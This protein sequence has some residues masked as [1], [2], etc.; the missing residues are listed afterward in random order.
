MSSIAEQ[1]TQYYDKTGLPINPWV[2]AR[3]VGSADYRLVD[4]SFVRPEPG[5]VMV[6]TQWF[7]REE[8][9]VRH[10][11]D[12]P[13]PHTFVTRVAGG[14]LDGTTWYTA[15]AA[16]AQLSHWAAVQAAARLASGVEQMWPAS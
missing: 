14:P 11:G 5:H 12:D 7:G 1:A 10:R 15:S 4:R 3:L 6:T 2:W 16:E 9:T 13:R 8:R